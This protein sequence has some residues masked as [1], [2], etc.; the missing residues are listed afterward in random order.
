[1]V[2]KSAVFE[3]TLPVESL[4]SMWVGSGDNVVPGNAIDTLL[5]GAAGVV[6]AL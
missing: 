1:M 4:H 2:V 3:I 5:P 6:V